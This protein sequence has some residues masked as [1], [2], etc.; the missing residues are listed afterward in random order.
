MA[1]TKATG[2]KGV[3]ADKFITAY[4]ALLKRSGKV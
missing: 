1:P 3:A 2:V 4:A